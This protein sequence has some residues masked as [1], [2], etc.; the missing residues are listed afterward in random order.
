MA[1]GKF[2]R[3]ITLE[4]PSNR[5]KASGSVE[6]VWTPVGSP[7]A[8]LV[9]ASGN[10]SAADDQV[11][12]VQRAVFRIRFRRDVTPAMRLIYRGRAYAINDVLEVDRNQMLQI[13]CTAL[14]VQSGPS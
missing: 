14:N 8:E 3:R 4:A 6:V 5:T 13:S 1:A 11:N 12:A 10:E 9:S 7:W 2:D